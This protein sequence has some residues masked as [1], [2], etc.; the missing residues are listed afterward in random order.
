MTVEW[1]VLSSSRPNPAGRLQVR[2][3]LCIFRKPDFPCL[4]ESCWGTVATRACYVACDPWERLEHGI[5]RICY[6]RGV[7][8]LCSVVTCNASRDINF[9]SRARMCEI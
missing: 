3:S 6:A 7:W 5:L 9:P 4:S 2:P 1:F 8:M